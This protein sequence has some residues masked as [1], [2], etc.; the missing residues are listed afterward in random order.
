MGGVIDI[1]GHKFRNIFKGQKGLSNILFSMIHAT[2]VLLL[3]YLLGNS[4]C[5]IGGEEQLIKHLYFIKDN[6]NL[7]KNEV[8]E[9]LLAV[10]VAYDKQLIEWSDE[11]GIPVGNLAI[12]NRQE[13]LEFLLQAKAVNN[14]GYIMLDVSFEQGIETLVDSSLF[15]TISRMERIVIPYH[16]GVTV[17]DSILMPKVAYAD[18]L[19]SVNEG[20][21]VKYQYINND[22]PSMAWKMYSDYTNCLY[23][24]CG[25]FSFCD[26]RLCHRCLF[27]NFSVNQEEGAYTSNGKKCFYN[28]GADLLNDS[29]NIDYA[30]LFKD[31]III[32]GD[33]TENDIHE[34]YV[35]AMCGAY[36]NYNAFLAL[37]NGKQY[38]NFGDMAILFVVYF[39]ITLFLMWNVSVFDYL[40]LLKN[41]KSFFW[42]F[43]FSLCGFSVLLTIVCGMFYFIEGNVYDILLISSYF[44]IFS[45]ALEFHRTIKA[46]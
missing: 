2:F 19:T 6:L 7:I 23:S 32:I 20:N 14:Y 41:V 22:K 11:Y 12:T 34:T 31:K 44:S 3:C 8:P 1:M 39:L 25:P 42:R 33:L 35:G 9:S 5:S 43:I 16:E 37:M 15:D 40:P 27:L 30:S 18:Y 26:G 10:N 13:L 46:K 28:L 45:T 17:A 29:G 38:V 4:A 21:F 36:I 24:H